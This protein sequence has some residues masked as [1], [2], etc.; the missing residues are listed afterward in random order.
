MRKARILIVDD[1]ED[2]R[3]FTR[4][5][6]EGCVKADVDTAANGE[7]AVT[8]VLREKFDLILLD[9]KMPGIS[10]L[11]VIEDAK[12]ANPDVDIIVISGWDSQQVA[13]EAIEKGAVDYITKP[14]KVEIF[15]MKIKEALKKKGL[16][17]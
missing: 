12:T 1:E 17:K 7:E 10:G 8:K 4:G 13:T 5:C 14:F 11:R 3:H 15:Q 2:I 16:I 9:I 6:I